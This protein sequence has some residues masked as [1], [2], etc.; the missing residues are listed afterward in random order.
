MSS[1]CAPDK[2]VEPPER[3]IFSSSRRKEWVS[4]RPTNARPSFAVAGPEIAS[5]QFIRLLGKGHHTL[6]PAFRVL[7]SNAHQAVRGFD[8]C[9][10]Q[11]ANSSRRS[12][13]S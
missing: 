13:Q 3:L 1:N 8:V 6:T 11:V 2:G 9:G 12:A 7:R 5:V 10:F 4:G